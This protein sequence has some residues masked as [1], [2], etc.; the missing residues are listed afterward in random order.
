MYQLVWWI[1]TNFLLF[2]VPKLPESLSEHPVLNAV[3]FLP[4][5]WSYVCLLSY[6]YI[7]SAPK[8]GSF[9]PSCSHP[10][11]FPL[12]DPFCHLPDPGFSLTESPLL[13]VAVLVFCL[14][15]ELNIL[16]M[17]S[18][19]HQSQGK[20]RGSKQGMRM[21]Q[22]GRMF[23]DWGLWAQLKLCCW[24]LPSTFTGWWSPS[25]VLMVCSF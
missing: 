21:G 6:S 7:A 25:T 4:S 11:S 18:N 24:T 12:L 9:S 23:S 20:A 10:D 2:F 3:T 17:E 16:I 22:T 1:C 19:K 8:W 5:G 14:F 13:L 15:S